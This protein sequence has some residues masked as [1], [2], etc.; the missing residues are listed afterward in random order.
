VI[1]VLLAAGNVL[2]GVRAL[3]R[4]GP[5]HALAAAA[6]GMQIYGLA[7]GLVDN[8]FFLVDLALMWWIAQATLL[9]L[10]EDRREACNGAEDTTTPDERV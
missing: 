2:A 8:A 1:L 10:G 6:L 7:H 4:P 3:R 5:D 9:A